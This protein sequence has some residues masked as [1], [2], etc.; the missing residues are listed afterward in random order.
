MADQPVLGPATFCHQ[1]GGVLYLWS[2]AIRDHN[3]AYKYQFSLIITLMLMHIT[4]PFTRTR[5]SHLYFRTT[6]RSRESHTKNERS[7]AMHSIWCLSAGNRQL[8]IV[9]S[10]SRANANSITVDLLADDGFMPIENVGVAEAPTTT[11]KNAYTLIPHICPSRHGLPNVMRARARA[12]WFTYKI[13]CGTLATH[14]ITHL[15]VNPAQIIPNVSNTHIHTHAHT[16]ECRNAHAN[17]EFASILI[18]RPCI[19]Q[20]REQ[21]QCAPPPHFVADRA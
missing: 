19:V 16:L 8:P 15:H 21:L 13:H 9:V 5:Y 4:N 18:I 3:C 1:S 6:R 11:T 14:I 12:R 17:N 7:A 20:H 2:E 10:I